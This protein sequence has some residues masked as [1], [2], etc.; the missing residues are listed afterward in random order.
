MSD[1][2]EK[3]QSSELN[4]NSAKVFDAAENS[5][6]L[7][8]RRDGEDFVLMSEREATA[9]RQLIELAAQLI[10]VTTD[11][12]GTLAE[13]MADRFPWMFALKAED[14][15]NCAKDL[16]AAARASFATQQIHL[17]IAE[18]TSWRETASAIAAGLS[19]SAIEWLDEPIE[20]VSPMA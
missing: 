8:T 20:A 2:L 5:P 13:R 12:R 14:R 17:A 11:D 10:A 9:R 16:V 4:R 15:E 7:V 18:L 6:I 19:L 1:L 3:F